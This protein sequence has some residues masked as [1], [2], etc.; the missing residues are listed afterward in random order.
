[1]PLMSGARRLWKAAPVPESVRH[2]LAAPLY[3]AT[4]AAGRLLRRP[5]PVSEIEPG[6]LLVSGFFG[7]VLGIGRGARATADALEAAGFTVLRHDVQ[8]VIHSPPYT[9][10]ELPAGP[11]GVWIQHCNAPENDL[12][13]SHL[14]AAAARGRY[15]IAYWAWELPTIPPLWRQTARAFHEIWTPSRFVADAVAPHA[16]QVRVMPHPIGAPPPAAPDRARFDLPAAA[17]VFAAFADARSALARKN[18]LGAVQAY[19]A[20]FPQE[21]GRTFLSIKVVAPDADGVGMAALL[22][23]AAGRS[24]IRIWSARLSEAELA[25]YL[26]SVD[27]VVSLHRS[28][29]FGLVVAEAYL[30]GKPVIATG[31]SGNLDFAPPAV[32]PSLI[33]AR[34]VP[35][36]DPSG[37]YQGGRWA[38]PDLAA[39]SAAMRDLL[40]RPEHRRPPPDVASA[41]LAQLQQPWRAEALDAQPWTRFLA[42]RT[43]SGGPAAAS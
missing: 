21:D 31:W 12:V 29:G 41:V 9:R 22:A 28:E 30:A 23:A 13:F 37:R 15:R 10:A 26:A 32:E 38:E 7:E 11:G 39:A 17:V 14:A 19:L 4:L 35:V 34:L 8:P 36:Q 43:A 24:D 1:M 20:A 42:A 33:P 27:V 5:T 3:N 25:C 16:R 18:P 6:P 2:A 40:A